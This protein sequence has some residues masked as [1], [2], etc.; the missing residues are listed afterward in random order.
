MGVAE[1][2]IRIAVGY[3]GIGLAVSVPFLFYGIDR[4]DDS[5]HGVYA[6]RPLLVPGII[7]LWPLVLVRWYVLARAAAA[8]PHGEQHS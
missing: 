6:F 4:V 1:L 3:A 7:L 5:A 8:A 2:L